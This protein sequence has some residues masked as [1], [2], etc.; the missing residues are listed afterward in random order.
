MEKLNGKKIIAQTRER[1]QGVNTRPLALL[2]T[3]VTVGVAFVIMLLQ[4]VLAEGIGNTGGLSGMATRSVLETLQM[5]LQLA[6]TILLPFWSLGFLYVALLWARE[7]QADKKDLL[8]GFRRIG[9]CLGLMVNRAVLTIIVMVVCINVCSTAY[10]LTPAGQE[11]QELMLSLGSI[12]NYYDYMSTLSQQELLAFWDAARPFFFLCFPLCACLVIP[13]LYRFRM[14]EFVILDQKG[15]RGIGA[16][17]LSAAL[18]RRRRWQLF[19]LDLR[20]WWYYGLKLLCTVLLYAD[21]LLGMVGVALPVGSG[22]AY[23]LTYVLYLAGLFAVEVSFRPR[24]ETAYACAYEQ[25][26]EGN[27]IEQKIV[28]VKP[29]NMPWDTEE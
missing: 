5:V 18:L 2:H 4:Y 24:V 28:P 10:L 3:G 11:L 1:L 17:I 7:T 26:K 15:I 13:L 16:M 23:I 12:E 25:L 27:P 22:M 20:F 21:V 6:N 19:K 9:P 29:Q 14:A 8:T